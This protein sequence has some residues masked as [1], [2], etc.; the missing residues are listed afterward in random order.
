MSSLYQISAELR[1]LRDKIEVEEEFAIDSEERKEIDEQ[2][3]IK[4]EELVQ[5]VDGYLHIISQVEA[6]SEM[7]QKEIERIQAFKKK[8]EHIVKRLQYA[9]LQAL[10]EFGEDDGG[11]RRLEVGT[12][13]LST[14][15]STSIQIND[16]DRVPDECKLCD[17]TFKNVSVD[18]KN[19]LTRRLQEL[20]DS[21]GKSELIG[22]L[23]PGTKVVKKLVSAYLAK[24]PVEESE[25]ELSE[26]K[27]VETPFAQQ[28]TK[29]SLVIK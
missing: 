14:R 8:K 18:I 1:S 4:Q 12:H 17:V 11:V 10:L 20:P 16:P 9:L 23:D 2:L 22:K 6:Q 13:R 27:E 7:A 25:D 5:K 15:R 21:Q 19:F 29:Y 28:V 24:N 26:D 3:V